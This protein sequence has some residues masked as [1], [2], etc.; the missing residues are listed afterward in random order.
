MWVRYTVA[1]ASALLLCAGVWSHTTI[2]VISRPSL[3][4]ASLAN[5]HA[6]MAFPQKPADP[7]TPATLQPQSRLAIIRFVDGEFAKLVRP[8]PRGKQG[9]KVSVGKPLDS[10]K[11]LETVR[12]EGAAANKGDT[13]Q[14]TNIEFRSREVVFEI[15]GGG[16]K[17]F[18]LRE[19]LQIGAGGST[20]PVPNPDARPHDGQGSTLIL[21]YGG[22]LPDMTP[23]DLKEELSVFLDFSQQRSAAV[24]WVETLPAEFQEGIKAHK[25]VE[26]MDQDT[27]IAAMGRPE[28][29]VRER[30]P[31]GNET[32]DW[33]YGNPPAKTIFVTFSS[34][35]VIRV[36]EFD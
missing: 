19:H 35:K 9:F 2:P 28:R 7:L 11:L 15:N 23:D 29:K 12:T 33:I 21:D 25:A 16:K 8:L 3:L 10:S 17:H 30:D 14:I 34:G 26:G 18:H 5:S 32:E 27:V 6:L 4:S 36:K 20:S 31:N 13:V 22:P 1:L 24:N